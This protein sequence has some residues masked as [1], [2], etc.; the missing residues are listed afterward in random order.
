ML[1]KKTTE[2]QNRSNTESTTLNFT[3]ESK[4]FSFA[5]GEVIY[6]GDERS[7]LITDF[8]CLDNVTSSSVFTIQV[9]FHSKLFFKVR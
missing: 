5:T 9:F 6:H 3:G 1:I 2:N 7:L 8:D 4:H